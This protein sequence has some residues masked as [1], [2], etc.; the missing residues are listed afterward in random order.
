MMRD[1]TRSIEGNKVKLVASDLSEF[2]VDV[3]VAFLSNT[4]KMFF[5]SEFLFKEKKTRTVFLPIRSTML[6]RIVEFMEYKHRSMSEQTL[7]EFKIA[8]DE[9]VALLDVASYLRI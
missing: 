3:D 4:L 7:N 8:D 2:V 9:T 5:D 1:R 6:R